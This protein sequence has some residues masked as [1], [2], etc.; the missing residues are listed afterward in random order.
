MSSESLVN[1][2]RRYIQED[3]NSYQ[4][5]CESLKCRHIVVACTVNG[6]FQWAVQLNALI[7]VGQC[8]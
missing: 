7:R 2:S 1:I 8:G 4:R 3:L 6:T 5:C